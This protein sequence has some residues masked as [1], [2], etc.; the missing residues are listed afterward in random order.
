MPES[1]LFLGE[2]GRPAT[3]LVPEPVALLQPRELV[4][5]E[6]PEGAA[7]EA[8]VVGLG[9]LLV[10]PLKRSM[11]STLSYTSCNCLMLLSEMKGLRSCRFTL[12]STKSSELLGKTAS[13]KC[14]KTLRLSRCTYLPGTTFRSASV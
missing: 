11:S 7:D 13:Q 3:A 9:L 14:D 4:V 1:N 5:D 6:T 2:G 12:V 10:I 8:V